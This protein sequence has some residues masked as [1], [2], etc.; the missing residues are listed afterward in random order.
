MQR[1]YLITGADTGL[2]AYFA[3]RCLA[4]AGNQVFHWMEK[5]GPYRQANFGELVARIVEESGGTAGPVLALG[6]DSGSEPLSVPSSAKIDEVW[7]FA[8]GLAGEEKRS[9]GLTEVLGSFSKTGAERFNF[10]GPA[11]GGRALELRAKKHCDQHKIPFRA[12]RT[13]LITLGAEGLV[14]EDANDFLHFLV[15]LFVYKTEIDERLAEYFDIQALRLT[16]SPDTRINLLGAR[17]AAGLLHAIAE[18]SLEANEFYIGNPE[19]MLLKEF[20][21]R[22]GMVYG[23]SLLSTLDQGKLNAIDQLFQSRISFFRAYLDSPEKFPW[24]DAWQVAGLPEDEARYDED[25]QV[26]VLESVLEVQRTERDA[27]CERVNELQNLEPKT[28]DAGGSPLSYYV[29]GGDGPP[30]VLLNALAQ[31]MYYWYRLI[32]RLMRHH[33]VVF[34]EPRGTV[35]PDRPFGLD[36][37]L[38]DLEAIVQEEGFEKFHIVA[39]CTGP[40]VAVKFCRKHPDMVPSMVFLNT[41]FKY[42]G[43]SEEFGELGADYEHN[44]ASLCTVLNSQ[45]NMSKSVMQSLQ[46]NFEVNPDNVLKITDGQLFAT[47][48]LAL[49]PPELQ[50]HVL[51]PFQT[52]GTTLKYARQILDFH[53]YDATGPARDVQTPVLLLGAEHDKVASPAMSDAVA[54]M[55]PRSKYV[56][57]AGATHYCLYNRPDFVA[58]LIEDFFHTPE[59]F[60]SAEA[61]ME[62]VA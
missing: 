38:A 2:A 8:G 22:C 27:E 9:E 5:R 50:P 42:A 12:F 25:A 39:W 14:D 36:D 60:V 10:I 18:Q 3:A 30:V 32:D 23:L 20:C 40:K 34:W 15:S 47:T 44:L 33:K 53:A 41:S 61:D 1:N 62:Q 59:K 37:Q 11:F 31:G 49:M 45:P 16:A 24:Q 46:A 6:G 17:E 58:G 13:S 48:V 7:H 51:A 28:I 29:A 26:A 55:F 21:E 54:K 4:S 56:Y 52:E 19:D 35:E 57:V 43:E